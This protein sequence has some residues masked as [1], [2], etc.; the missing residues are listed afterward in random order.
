MQVNLP[1]EHY[2]KI[3]G[4]IPDP[5]TYPM[6]KVGQSLE[7]LRKKAHLR[8]RGNLISCIARI[9]NNLAYATH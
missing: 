9:R 7:T 5:K 2:I 3:L 6:A 8:A 1:N 4:N